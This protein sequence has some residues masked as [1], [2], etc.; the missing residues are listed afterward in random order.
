MKI[1]YQYENQLSNQSWLQL[2]DH[3]Q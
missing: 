3:E 2:P 1:N